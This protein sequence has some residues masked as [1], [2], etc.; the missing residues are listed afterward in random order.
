[1]SIQ[2]A[3]KEDA[4]ELFGKSFMEACKDD[5]WMAVVF[6]IRNGKPVVLRRTCWNFPRV[7]FNGASS[8]LKKI[9]DA[10]IGDSEK[11]T[12]PEPLDLAE[13]LRIRQDR[14]RQENKSIEN[15]IIPTECGIGEM[16]DTCV[17]APV[18]ID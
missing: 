2:H 9:N 5:Q 1:M 14:K 18:D 10:D 8:E 16:V 6:V 11:P 4:M 7:A 17:K 13:F 12:I 15:S 3:T